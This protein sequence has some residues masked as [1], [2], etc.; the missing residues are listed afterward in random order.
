MVPCAPL[1]QF[2]N[3]MLQRKLSVY[4]GLS[5]Q[6]MFKISECFYK[7]HQISHHKIRTENVLSICSALKAFTPFVDLHQCFVFN[8]EIKKGLVCKIVHNF[9]EKSE[10]SIWTYRLPIDFS[11]RFFH[12]STSFLSRMLRSDN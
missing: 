4:F 12:K 1:R 11:I 3:S 8:M 6:Q 5:N 10:R 2:K 7:I 9:Q